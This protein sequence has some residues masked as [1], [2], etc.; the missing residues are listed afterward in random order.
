MVAPDPAPAQP[1]SAELLAWYDRHRRRLPWRA[2]PGETPDPYRV[3]LSE[4]MLQQTTVMA[5]K[6]YF[7]AFTR[8]FP[9]VEALAAAPVEEVM[10]LWAGLGYY[11]RARN[12]HTC[13][14]AVTERFGGRFPADEATLLTLPGIGAYT[15]AAVSA[16]AFDRRAVVVDGNVERVVTR[17]HALDEP[18]PA[19][20]P[21]IRRLADALTPDTRPGDFAQAMMDL[22]ATICTPRRPSCA[23][24]PFRGACAA[25]R[26]GTQE[27]YPRKMPKS[28]NATRYGA[29][30]VAVRADGALLVR[31][32]P[33]KGLLGGMTEVP[34]TDWTADESLAASPVAAPLAAAWR[35]CPIPARHGFTHFPLEV[36]VWRADVPTGTP[37]PDGMRWIAADEIADEAFPT[38]FRK[39]LAVGL[40]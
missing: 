18:L 27:T 37:A 31:T 14:Q 5:V 30:F 7:E 16:I 4:I 21:A 20:K 10:R 34:G 24:C 28:V 17:L 13:A 39:V 25:Q 1:D 26:A 38:V 15:A 6:P 36:T 22:G 9:T 12:L 29:A 2:L 23:L 35:R 32:R 40:A 3:W 11:S 33:P 19:A 8:R